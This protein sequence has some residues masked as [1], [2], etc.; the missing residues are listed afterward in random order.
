MQC[1]CRI[2]VARYM[3][4][5]RTPRTPKAGKTDVSDAVEELFRTIRSQASREVQQD[6]MQFRRSSC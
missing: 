5:P 4:T 1:L 3:L 6:G 2:A